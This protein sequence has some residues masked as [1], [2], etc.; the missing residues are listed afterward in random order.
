MEDLG[1]KPND[2]GLERVRVG[3]LDINLV[4]PSGVDG[5]GRRGKCALEPREIGGVDG[6]GEDAR[7]VPVGSN[8]G[9]LFRNASFSAGR[10]GGS[11]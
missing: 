7:L 2:G 1:I 10:H 8:V 3:N 6:L 5:I 9:E 11:G 4:R